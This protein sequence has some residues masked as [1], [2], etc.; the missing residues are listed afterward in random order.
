MNGY[1]LAVGKG[2]PHLKPW[3]P[4]TLAPSPQSGDTTAQS[5]AALERIGVKAVERRGRIELTFPAGALKAG[6]P[7]V[8]GKTTLDQLARN[9]S[10]FLRAPVVNATGISGEYSISIHASPVGASGMPRLPG[11]ETDEPEDPTPTIQ[12]EVKKLGLDLKPGKVDAEVLV[13]ERAQRLP[14]PN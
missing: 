7:V 4:S 1:T 5:I 12:S 14:E 8:F 2:G 11:E 9:L 13:V 10:G 3:E 6:L